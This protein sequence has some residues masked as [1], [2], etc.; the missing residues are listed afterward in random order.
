VSGT[1]TANG[2]S[3]FI[4]QVTDASS[5]TATRGL[6]LS[7]SASVTITTTTLPG[8]T[9]GTSYSQQL[10][11]A[12]GATPYSWTLASGSL[13]AGLGLSTSG[14]I[15]GTPTAAGSASFTVR[16]T[17][18]ASRSATQALTLTVSSSLTIGTTTVAGGVVGAAYSQQ[19]VASGG[20]T[21]YSWAISS[22][23]PPPG[24][25]LSSTGLLSGTPTAV[26][27]TTFTVRVTDAASRTDTQALTLTV[28]SS[29]QITTTTLPPGTTGTNYNQQLVASGGVTPY[30]WSL[31]SGALPDGISLSPGGMLSGI[32]T[33]PVNASFTVRAADA[34]GGSTTQAL[35]LV[36]ASPPGITTTALATAVSGV[37]YSQTLAVTGGSPPYAWSIASGTPPD[38]L[39]LSGTGV[40]SGTPTIA[41]DYSFTVQVTDGASRTA[42]QVLGVSVAAGQAAQI[43]WLQ[44]PTNTVVDVPIS[45]AP[46]VRVQDMAGN[47]VNITAVVGMRISRPSGA[48]FAASSTTTAETVEGVASFSNLRI[49]MKEKSV[50]LRATVGNISSAESANFKVE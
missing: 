49:A 24:L 30:T 2:S 46:R 50:R 32:P 19:L 36:V 26:G 22:G 43:I 38:G 39:T 47:A 35:T 3:T 5:R 6:T 13:P 33:T 7:V 28:T 23:T 20:T 12:G 37:A 44:Q 17:D 21:P 8:G 11:A 10:S 48:D 1:P 41:G 29:L 27:S 16:V 40:L 18:A 4:V 14:V 42:V 15:S 31:A 45:P 34:G 25:S 9:V